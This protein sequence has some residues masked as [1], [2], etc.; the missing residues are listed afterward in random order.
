MNLFRTTGD[1]AKPLLSL[2]GISKHFNGVASLQS[3]DLDLYPGEILGLVG[4]NGAGKSTLIKILAGAHKPDAGRIIIR[5]KDVDLRRYTVHAARLAGIETVYQ[6]GSFGW[7]QP[8]WRN[9]FLGRALKNRF[10]FI[11]VKEQKR[12]TLDIL[13]NHIGLR[14][15]GVNCDA[16]LRNLSGGE[17]QGLAIGRAM[18]FDADIIVLDEPT[19]ALSLHEVDTVLS[20]VHSI[21][22]S[23][24]GCIYISH[25]MNHVASLVSRVVVLDKGRIVDNFITNGGSVSDISG[26]IL[27]GIGS[28]DEVVA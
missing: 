25:N 24:K 14:G 20:F 5:G 17:R 10:G 26:R 11:N 28:A 8:L 9:V 13:C 15:A 18:H 1:S 4:D 22:G 23:S 3:V 6:D 2:R 16:K 19:T 7:K 21:G 12:V 27:D